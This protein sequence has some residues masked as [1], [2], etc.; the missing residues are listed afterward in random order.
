M[1]GIFGAHV[2]PQVNTNTYTVN[3][4]HADDGNFEQFV[5]SRRSHY[6]H[7]GVYNY[8]NGSTGPIMGNRV[9]EN[10]GNIINMAPLPTL[11]DLLR[12]LFGTP[13]DR[14]SPDGYVYGDM[15][16][17][18]Y[19]PTNMPPPPSHN[20]V[21]HMHSHYAATG[22]L[23]FAVG[24][25]HY[26]VVKNSDGNGEAAYKV[27]TDGSLG[28]MID[29]KV[30]YGGEL[31]VHGFFE[32]G[33]IAGIDKRDRLYIGGSDHT[34]QISMLVATAN[35]DDTDTFFGAAKQEMLYSLGTPLNGPIMTHPNITT[36]QV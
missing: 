29:Q 11:M 1:F 12:N 36:T 16:P 8:E 13:A 14:F 21:Q 5:A 27:N 34:G 25:Q 24:N 15:Q 7:P 22:R 23:D 9:L 30:Q 31:G 19:P 26:A 6:A 3:T 2:Q 33:G 28:E 20:C 18:T 32:V 4:H 35:I 17:T 10:M